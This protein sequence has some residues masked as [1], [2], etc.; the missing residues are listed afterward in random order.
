MQTSAHKVA[1][2]SGWPNP[3]LD[4]VSLRFI[5][6]LK[7]G[8]RLLRADSSTTNYWQ[9]GS[10]AESRLL[11]IICRSKPTTVVKKIP[12][13]QLDKF[14]RLDQRDYAAC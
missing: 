2:S 10:S 9:T 7:N 1:P 12:D 4:P 14:D 13:H 5:D 8:P 6:G 3:G 11:D